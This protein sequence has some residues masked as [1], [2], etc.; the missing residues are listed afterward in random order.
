[1]NPV[2]P[3][4]LFVMCL[5][6]VAG[7][8]S[9]VSTFDR[10]QTTLEPNDYV[11]AFSFDTTALADWPF[12]SAMVDLRNG[13]PIVMAG[14]ESGVTMV[15]FQMSQSTLKLGDLIFSREE[16]EGTRVYESTVVGPKV[17]LHKGSVTYIGSLVVDDILRDEETGSPLALRLRIVDSWESNEFAWESMFPVFEEHDPARRVAAGWGDSEELGLRLVQV[18]GTRQFNPSRYTQRNARNTSAFH[19]RNKTIP[20]KSIRKPP[21]K[22]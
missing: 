2:R 12:D 18:S 15:V 6:L 17:K 16:Y 20:P 7:G 3:T 4:W 22:N 5:V 10:S 13:P 11:A 9:T 8:C 21:P 14:N 1:M 19:K